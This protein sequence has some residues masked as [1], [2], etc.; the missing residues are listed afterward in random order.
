MASLQTSRQEAFLMATTYAHFAQNQ[1]LYLNRSVGSSLTAYN[2]A[3]VDYLGKPEVLEVDIHK[4]EEGYGERLLI[5][6]RDNVKVLAV[7]VSVR[8]EGANGTVFEEGEADQSET[9]SQLWTYTLRSPLPRTP[10]AHL[11]VIAMDLPGNV[12]GSMVELL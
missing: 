1:P 11:E 4:D 8:G 7:R 9:D 12:A 3:V 5:K 2:W 6:A 10:G